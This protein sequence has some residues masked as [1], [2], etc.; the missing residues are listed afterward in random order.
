MSHRIL[1]GLALS[2]VGLLM[3]TGCKSGTA[4]GPITIPL[5]YP[6]VPTL[7]GVQVQMKGTVAVVVT[8]QR[9]KKD[10]V[11]QNTQEATP[12]AVL[13]TDDPAAF[14]RGVLVRQLQARGA[15]IAA[16]GASARRQFSL[17][18]TNFY[19]TESDLYRST[20]QFKAQVLDEKGKVLW[21]GVVDGASTTWG[22]NYKADNYQ[23]TLGGAAA[24][25]VTHLLADPG[26][27]T[28]LQ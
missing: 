16:A 26:V 3:A 20:V 4:A 23:Q 15:T 8:D 9:D 18:L 13:T 7:D 22:S 2:L 6:P 17:Q 1:A 5:Q 11:G 28:A 12:R 21:E 24:D 14:V 19:C 27:A 25:A 10:A